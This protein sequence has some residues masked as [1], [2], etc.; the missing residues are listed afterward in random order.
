MHIYPTIHHTVV[1]P[2]LLLLSPTSVVLFLMKRKVMVPLR[3]IRRNEMRSDDRLVIVK[4][5]VLTP[6]A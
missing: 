1:P 5:E 4:R 6:A 2:L 3:L